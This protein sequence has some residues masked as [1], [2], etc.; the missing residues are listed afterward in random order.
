MVKPVCCGP[1][2]LTGPPGWTRGIGTPGP[3]GSIDTASSNQP[4]YNSHHLAKKQKIKKIKNKIIFFYVFQQFF[5]NDLRWSIRPPW[6]EYE[7]ARKDS[8]NW[9]QVSPADA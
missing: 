4:G 8:E 6:T 9:P 5:A 2:R 1:G 3:T 7:K